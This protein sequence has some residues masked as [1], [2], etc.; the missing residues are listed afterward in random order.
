MMLAGFPS[1][2]G[3]FGANGVKLNAHHSQHDNLEEMKLEVRKAFHHLKPGSI[4]KLGDPLEFR[5][6]SNLCPKS[7][8]DSRVPKLFT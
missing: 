3:T 5:H 4:L 8:R 2:F 1:H 6:R 7:F